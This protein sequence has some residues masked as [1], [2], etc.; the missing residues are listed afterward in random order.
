MSTQE[1]LLL[2]IIN[3]ISALLGAF[4]IALFWFPDKF[5]QY[6]NLA[7]GAII[8]GVSVGSAISLGGIIASTLGLDPAS[9]DVALGIGFIVG[10]LSMGFLNLLANF[11]AKRPDSDLAQ[12]LDEIKGKL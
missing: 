8:G 12:I 2:K 3:G 5:K 10:T 7:I 1:F 6:G 11:F 9:R 4:S